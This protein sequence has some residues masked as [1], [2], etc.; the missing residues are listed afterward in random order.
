[1]LALWADEL[2]HLIGSVYLR[3]QP[4]QAVLR[5]RQNGLPCLRQLLVNR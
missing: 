1:M 2:L 4:E 3:Q 5:E